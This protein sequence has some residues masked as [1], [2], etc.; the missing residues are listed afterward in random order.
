MYEFLRS[1]IESSSLFQEGLRRE[2]QKVIF[3]ILEIRGIELK[4]SGLAKLCLMSLEAEE[5]KELKEFAKKVD[6]S[7]EFTEKIKELLESS[8]MI[9]GIVRGYRRGTADGIGKIL[10]EKKLKYKK[11]ELDKL[12]GSI[13]IF[14][15]SRAIELA[16]KSDSYEEFAQR[17]KGL[18]TK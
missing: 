7:E 3:E 2:I 8:P 14:D 11:S 4:E 17:V 13:E 1:L 15:L 18:K 9:I 12:I 10:K 5:L 6:T 16:R